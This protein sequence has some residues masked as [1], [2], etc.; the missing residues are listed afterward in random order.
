[1]DHGNRSGYGYKTPSS[2]TATAQ[3]RAN[4][5]DT[6]SPTS[7]T[8]PTPTSG[9]RAAG[10][11]N[12]SGVTHTAAEAG[13]VAALWKGFHTGLEAVFDAI[14]DVVTMPFP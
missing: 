11:G 12:Q 3:P 1:M 9:P 10:D 5:S 6:P 13:G 8:A 4:G 7:N 14:I 2:P